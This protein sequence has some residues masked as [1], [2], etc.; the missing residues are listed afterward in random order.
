[1]H[2]VHVLKLKTVHELK[3]LN[4]ENNHCKHRL[5]SSLL[6]EKI[7]GRFPIQ[8]YRNIRIKTILKFQNLPS[9][10][11]L[12]L[13]RSTARVTARKKITCDELFILIF[14]HTK[15][16]VNLS[17]YFHQFINLFQPYGTTR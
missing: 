1:M 10:D 16:Y 8:A 3:Q 6:Q 7:K 11:W 14:E 12:T 2:Q 13:T 15:N 5:G 17:T 9:V 4:K